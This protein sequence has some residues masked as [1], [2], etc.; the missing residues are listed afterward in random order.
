MHTASKEE[1]HPQA[2]SKVMSICC[3]VRVM[4]K[5]LPT[6]S[7]LGV[8]GEAKGHVAVVW[9]DLGM[10]RGVAHVGNVSGA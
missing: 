1:G 7:V 8:C 2:D 6:M 3:S 4:Q 5:I 9:V 10:V